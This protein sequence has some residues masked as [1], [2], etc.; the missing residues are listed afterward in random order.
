MQLLWGF[1]IANLANLG[2]L[3]CFDFKLTWSVKSSFVTRLCFEFFTRFV[4][5][6]YL[7]INQKRVFHL[8]LILAKVTDLQKKAAAI[9]QK[10]K[11]Q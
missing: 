2:Q 6:F 5:R 10:S 11:L 3:F 9:E 7:R 4:L 8:S 1:Q